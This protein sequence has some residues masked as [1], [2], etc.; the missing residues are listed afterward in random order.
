MSRISYDRIIPLLVGQQPT[1]GVIGL[2]REIIVLQSR[3][4]NTDAQSFYFQKAR[5]SH[6]AKLDKMKARYSHIAEIINNNDMD[7]FIIKV[8]EFEGKLQKI[9][10]EGPSGFIKR[11][12]CDMLQN[13]IDYGND[14][15]QIKN[16]FGRLKNL[17]ELFEDEESM[18]KI[19]SE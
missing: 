12:T 1:S 18:M 17:D 19:F 9:K 2:I 14:L 7:F 5:K 10:S 16:Q 6:Q 4:E 13:D 3:L 8:N 11:F 15:I